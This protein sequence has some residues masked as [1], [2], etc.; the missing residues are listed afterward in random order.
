LGGIEQ[1]GPVVSRV[2]QTADRL[3]AGAEMETA[4]LERSGGA[5]EAAAGVDSLGQRFE[6]IP[7]EVRARALIDRDPSELT[8]EDW[9]TIRDGLA[10]DPRGIV[11]NGPL[12]IHGKYG[13]P[14]F[15]EVI[16]AHRL[17]ESS[18]IED[19]DRYFHVW[20]KAALNP[21][22]F[23]QEFNAL[24]IR[25]PYHLNNDE[26]KELLHYVDADPRGEI[27]QIPA[28][29]NDDFEPLRHNIFGIAR[30]GH[31]ISERLLAQCFRWQREHDPT[32]MGRVKEAVA[33]GA[34]N[35][36][37]NEQFWTLRV[38]YDRLNQVKELH[39]ELPPTQ[40]RDVVYYM[41]GRRHNLLNTWMKHHD[42]EYESMLKGSVESFLAGTADN[43]QKYLLEGAQERFGELAAGR[44]LGD[45]EKLANAMLSGHQLSTWRFRN[46]PTWST[47]I[48]EAVEQVVHSDENDYDARRIVRYAP[49]LKE[50]LA[51]KPFLYE[52]RIQQKVLIGNTEMFVQWLRKNA[53]DWNERLH[54]AADLAAQGGVPGDVHSVEFQML[55][56]SEPRLEELIAGRPYEQQE[57]IACAVL[58]WNIFDDW[59]HEHDP[60]L[61]ARVSAA[62]KKFVDG[63]ELSEAE[64][65]LLHSEQ[66]RID[67]MTEGYP[68]DVQKKIAYTFTGE[69]TMYRAEWDE[70]HNPEYPRLVQ[71]A[72]DAELAGTATSLQ[73]GLMHTV[74]SKFE[75]VFG[76]RPLVEFLRIAR[77]VKHGHHYTHWRKSQYPALFDAMKVSAQNAVHGELSEDD[78][79]ILANSYDDIDQLVYGKPHDAQLRI[80]RAVYGKDE[81]S[82]H[83]WTARNEP[84]RIAA[85]NTAVNEVLEGTA[86]PHQKRM[87]FNQ[88]QVLTSTADMPYDDRLKLASV[89]YDIAELQKWSRANDPAH[90]ARLD[91]AIDAIVAGD[92]SPAAI[93]GLDED[94]VNLYR[95]LALRPREHQGDVAVALA[96]DRIVGAGDTEAVKLLA[97]DLRERLQNL[98]EHMA[99]VGQLKTTALELIDRN[100]KRMVG[101]RVGDPNQGWKQYP[102][103]AELSEAES[104]VEMLEMMAGQ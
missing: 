33:A 45:Q 58:K 73:T 1:A 2:V 66:S 43:W 37:T 83:E 10:A 78:R 5:A 22:T 42:V 51:A 79:V 18:K 65:K 4:A 89:V 84:G 34:N 96:K 90:L 9:N 81:R 47:Q 41:M 15:T 104:Q 69:R 76:D 31:P 7:V 52:E 75:Q 82:L 101:M 88:E 36:L 100:L 8:V 35:K 103:F 44:A 63:E 87:L 95:R 57:R 30:G 60:A 92:T 24:M 50:I 56:Q 72:A 61:R 55:R 46:D 80:A 94:R 98:P 28:I 13:T 27:T 49:N 86:T 91:A 53:P 23:R 70:R 6:A 29:K 16:D 14:T 77:R 85:T 39:P 12:E 99:D 102:D 93:A 74:Y 68:F 97:L 26:W 21:E 20:R 67:L 32:Y 71:E 17:G 48:A 25:A 38:E 54:A 11:M 40:L 3:R 19:A 62:V 59:K 64:S